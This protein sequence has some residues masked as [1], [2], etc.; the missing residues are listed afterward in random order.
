[1]FNNA[2]LKRLYSLYQETLDHIRLPPPSDYVEMQISFTNKLMHT[3]S[4]PKVPVP[5]LM[6]RGSLS[7]LSIDM[8]AHNSLGTTRLF[9]NDLLV[10]VS[11]KSALFP[12]CFCNWSYFMFSLQRN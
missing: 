6:T 2:N 1:M 10:S 7:Q 9:A 11:V 3:P 5:S 12:I 4:Q 8:L